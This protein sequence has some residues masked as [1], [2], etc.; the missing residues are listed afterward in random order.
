MKVLVTGASGF[1]GQHVIPHLLERGH[2]VVAVARDKTK[3]CDFTW[4]NSV[5]FIEYDI[6]HVSDNLI[7]QFEY[8][9]VAIHLAWPGLPNYESLFHFEENLPASYRFLKALIEGGVSHL[10]ITGTCFEYGMQSGCLTEEMPTQPVNPYALAKDT[11]RKFLQAL[12]QQKAFTLQWARLF[13]MHGNGQNPN[14]LIAQLHRAINNGET[15]FNMS[16][17]EQL[18]DYLP[19]EEV[20]RRI[21]MLLEHPEY[22]GIVNLCSGEPISIRRL[23]EQHLIHYGIDM[24]LNLGY[25][26]LSGYEPIAFWGE[27][28][29]FNKNGEI[30]CK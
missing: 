6:H 5:R 10:L 4:F 21:A 26:P 28:K 13:Y 11:L 14:S 3:A 12:Q 2:I 22:N 1:V 27:S 30:L 24:R 17:G 23:V 16:T 19:V 29:I 8:P 18:R 7:E 20:G 15:S 25:Y 9:E